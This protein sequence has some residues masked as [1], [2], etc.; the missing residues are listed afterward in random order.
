[1]IAGMLI[2]SYGI[3]TAPPQPPGSDIRITDDSIERITDNEDRRIT[4]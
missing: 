4:D 2:M 3:F 1:M